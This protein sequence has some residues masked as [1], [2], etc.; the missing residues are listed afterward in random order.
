ME[1][2]TTLSG[3]GI[4]KL[5]YF[6]ILLIIAVIGGNIFEYFL[7]KITFR[8]LTV[9]NNHFEESFTKFSKKPV[10]LIFV[11]FIIGFG[12][13]LINFSD[14]ILLFVKRIHGALTILSVAWLLIS[15]L[16]VIESVILFRLDI[17]KQDNLK[18]RKI[19]TQI[20][21]FKNISSFI[22]SVL[23]LAMILTN[24]EQIRQIGI[25]LLAS[26]G[27]AGIIIGF[28]AQKSISTLIAGIQIAFTQP[29]R[30][31]DVV[32]VENEWGW[33]EEITLTYVVVRIWDLR[34]IILPITYFL[35][36]PFY[37]WTRQSADILGTVFI[38]VDYT[39]SIEKIRS[40]LSELLKN[41]PK[42]DGR[43]CSLQVTNLTEKTMELRALMS[44]KDSPILWDL[45][46]EIREELINYIKEEYP[47][48]LPLE[49]VNMILSDLNG[50]YK[51]HPSPQ[52]ST[53]GE[54]GS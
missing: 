44:A 33:I 39:V 19:F 52:P 4:D 25:S 30:I 53:K 6:L 49:R 43:V 42:W 40:K 1:I 5:L 54:G 35:E 23:A 29:I 22:I 37:N 27:V 21:V 38:Y 12:L 51:Y 8:W 34:R 20:N 32:V 24:F 2:W 28:A 46:C 45:R 10:I 7:F 13:P 3:F 50:Y 15:I 17:S 41:N 26:A 14:N 11:L 48:S 47:E 16:W 36:K 18:E 31:D 9:F